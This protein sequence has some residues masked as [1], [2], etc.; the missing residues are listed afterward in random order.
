MKEFENADLADPPGSRTFVVQTL[1][2]APARMATPSGGTTRGALPAVGRHDSGVERE[3]P[4]G[5]PRI[6]QRR[7]CGHG[8]TFR[9][10]CAT[11]SVSGSA[12]AIGVRLAV[13]YTQPALPSLRSQ[14]LA[15]SMELVQPAD[16]FNVLVPERPELPPRY[17]I[18]PTQPVA[19]VR[20][21]PHDEGRELVN[22]WTQGQRTARRWSSFFGPSPADQMAAYPVSTFVNARVTR[23]DSTRGG[24]KAR[25]NFYLS[26]RQ[27]AAASD[28][29]YC[30]YCE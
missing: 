29:E 24:Q 10:Y 30:E 27:M 8:R 19:A 23:A 14:S 12:A 4:R 16:F 22:G 3:R 17:N 1:A 7:R 11:W 15:F 26:L 2:P 28:C 9:N 25:R 20:I 5:K 6:V 13:G 18:A 21:R